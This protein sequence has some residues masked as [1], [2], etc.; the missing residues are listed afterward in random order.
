MTGSAEDDE[1]GGVDVE[2]VGVLTT[3]WSSVCSASIRLP[4]AY[5]LLYSSHSRTQLVSGKVGSLPEM[6][7]LESGN[8]WI[9]TG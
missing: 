3:R 1:L 7:P 4:L 6:S 2:T 8:A 5:S 9:F